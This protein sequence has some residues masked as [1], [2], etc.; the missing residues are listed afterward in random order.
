[1]KY[2]LHLFF[3]LVIGSTALAAVNIRPLQ[4]QAL[5]DA[6]DKNLKTF[7]QGAGYKEDSEPDAIYKYIGQIVQLMLYALGIIFLCLIIYGGFEWMQSM[8]NEERVKKAQSI[9]R[10]ATIGLLIVVAAYALSIFATGA[11][12]FLLK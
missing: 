10:N 4:A 5:N 8:G 6:F 12:S 7:N 9:L 1:M 2:L 3:I 11:L